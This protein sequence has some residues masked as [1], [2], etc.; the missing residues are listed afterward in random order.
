MTALTLPASLP[1]SN[2]HSP[3][4]PVSQP[5]PAAPSTVSRRQFWILIAAVL[6][7]LLA[8]LSGMFAY[9]RFGG[10]GGHPAVIP[11]VQDATPE[12]GWPQFRGGAARTG[13]SSDPGPGADLD[14]RWTFTS[15]DVMINVVT[16]GNTVYVSGRKGD[17]WAL[18]AATG[19]Q[20]WAVDLSQGE[21]NDE[22]RWP[23][24]TV[25]DGMVYQGTYDGN[26]V[27]LNTIDGS[28]VWQK[29]IS[30]DSI[31]A[32]FAAVDD[33]LFVVTPK[34]TILDL[35]ATTGN[36]NWEW[37]GDTELANWADAVGG[38]L[39]YIADVTGS[40]VAIDTSTGTTKWISELGDARRNPAYSDGVVY[41]GGDNGSY[42]AL[43]ATDGSV[44]WTSD[45]F[46]TG[47]TLNPVVTP[48]E[49]IVSYETGPLEAL[50]FATGK[51]IWTAEGPGSSQSAHA[52]ATAVYSVSAD[53]TA[54][55]AYDLSTG[56]EVGRVAADGVGSVAAISGDTIVYGGKG[57]VRSF[58]PGSGDVIETTPGPST[59]L[60][61]ATPMPAAPP[62]ASPSAFDS[63]QVGMLWQST[64]SPAEPFQGPIG[65]AV[66]PDGTI[67]VPDDV[68]STIQ[69]LSPDG[70]YLETW[71]S[72]GSSPG[73]FANPGSL[74]FDADGN[75]FVFDT[76]NHRVQKFGPDRTFLKQWGTK[77]T[78]NGQFDEVQG[79]V[80][81][82]AGTVY[83]VEF[84]NH[85]V[86]VFDLDG[87]YLDKWGS[88]GTGNG[89]FVAPVSIEVGPD[90]MIYVG[91]T[92][93]GTNARVQIFDQFGTWQGTLL[94]A[95][96]N[97]ANF[98]E[99]WG[100]AFDA[101]GNIYVSDYWRQVIYVFDPEWREIGQ[102]AD[103]AGAG[104][105]KSP[106]R[107]AFDSDGNLYVGDYDNHRVLKLAMPKAS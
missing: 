64:G 27:A 32:S 102:I 74:G 39:L 98:S 48:N 15:D 68:T 1:A 91:D 97:P 49:L 9:D 17:L 67:Y 81:P 73:Q 21:Y 104:P 6:A 11:A 8:G 4:R 16:D 103:V 72:P 92:N 38:G 26:I 12:S 42:Y 82:I 99:A 53:Q 89:Q 3:G 78:G 71:G 19:A 2:G 95:D 50:D 77:G 83:T 60:G 100:I 55:V 31:V 35:D 79:T 69:I 33:S 58:G 59:V 23:I 101:V 63:S 25:S 18:D 20:R 5:H 34:G 56:K 10:N 93:N 61:V 66:A 84:S 37:T 65:V 14:P 86:Q 24:P 96:G 36:T 70:T 41:V 76:E 7:L 88:V 94:D 46:T 80:D 87:N 57:A 13:Y 106:A 40:L 107:L 30:T 28:V 105:F 45:P 43:D 44:I 75:I 62:V 54:L 22:N 90:G 52:S 51:V 29:A 47:Q 85:R